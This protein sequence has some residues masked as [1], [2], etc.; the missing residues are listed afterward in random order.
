MYHLT[1]TCINKCKNWIWRLAWHG[2]LFD[3]TIG[4]D[5]CRDASKRQEHQEV[6]HT[7]QQNITKHCWRHLVLPWS[8]GA[9][10][11]SVAMAKINSDF[12]TILGI[13]KDTRDHQGPYRRKSASFHCISKIW[14]WHPMT[15]EFV[16][17]DF[18]QEW[19]AKRDTSVWYQLCCGRQ[20]ASFDDVRKVEFAAR[21]ELNPNRPSWMVS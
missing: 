3:F 10:Y 4:W 5:D 12:Y 8:V 17:C 19:W 13:G 20:D 7:Q 14:Q 1:W 2:F 16:A 18:A 9:M 21:E 15:M 6:H 11:S